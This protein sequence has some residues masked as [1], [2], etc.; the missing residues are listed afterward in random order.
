[1]ETRLAALRDRIAL[2]RAI[3]R[4]RAAELP[5]PGVL[6]E[7]ELAA[8]EGRL[9][10]AL[11]AW[12]DRAAPRIALEGPEDPA[13]LEAISIA[14]E[15]V[16][17]TASSDPSLLR[18]LGY[19]HLRERRYADANAAFAAAAVAG[20]PDALAIH[21]LD[22]ARVELARGAA[23][24]SILHAERGLACAD[25]TYATRDELRDTLE[26][27]LGMAGRSEEALAVLDLRAAEC[28]V[29]L[30]LHHRL[31]R[32][33]LARGDIGGAASVLERAAAM[34]LILGVPASI[35]DR[36]A[37]SFDPIIRELAGARKNHEVKVMTT[38]VE[39]IRG[40]N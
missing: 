14:F 26:R 9:D 11:L 7:A 29:G 3:D 8:A 27:A 37:A 25:L 24:E 17:K 20:G 36:L 18:T 22:R 4:E 5:R 16:V 35:D 19:L 31:A 28:E 33:R 15:L 40:A 38:L 1:V 13:E 2:L 30:A 21:H 32:E 10:R 6:S 12:A 23:D 39:R 34:P